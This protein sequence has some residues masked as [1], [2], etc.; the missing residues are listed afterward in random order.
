MKKK[1]GIA[2]TLIISLIAILLTIDYVTYSPEN[3]FEKDTK[4]MVNL[5]KAKSIDLSPLTAEDEARKKNYSDKYTSNPILNEDQKSL[6]YKYLLLEMSYDVYLSHKYSEDKEKSK[7]S[8]E[9][10]KVFFDCLRDMEDY[11]SSN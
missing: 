11:I 8:N 4:E 3:N 5:Y 6:I 2:I 7:N 1:I 9:S 10:I